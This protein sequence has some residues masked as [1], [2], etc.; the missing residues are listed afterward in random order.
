[1]KIQQIL[2]SIILLIILIIWYFFKKNKNTLEKFQIPDLNLECV[3]EDIT[4]Q[5]TS[6]VDR[7]E[8]VQDCENHI[9]YS[10][11]LTNFINNTDAT[12]A[13]TTNIVS[14]DMNSI[15]I[16]IKPTNIYQI[17]KLG[18][19]FKIDKNVEG[20]IM[21]LKFRRTNNGIKNSELNYEL[22]FHITR[23]DSLRINGHT[24]AVVTDTTTTTTLAAINTDPNDNKLTPKE[25]PIYL[26]ENAND[27][28][29][30]LYITIN[31]KADSFI[32]INLN[33]NI[34]ISI[35]NTDLFQPSKPGTTESSDRLLDWNIHTFN[36]RVAQI[37]A[38]TKDF[39][40]NICDYYNCEQNNPDKKCNFDLEDYYT[41]NNNK[42][43]NNKE[44]CLSACNNE[45][46]CNIIDCQKRCLECK[47]KN[48]LSFQKGYID[49][50]CPWYKNLIS[51][52]EAPDAPKIR[53]FSDEKHINKKNIPIIVIEWHK[54]ES[55]SSEIQQ[56]I[57]EIEELGIGSNG[58]Q[59]INV[60]Y[61]GEKTVQ[62]DLTNL[63][64]QT[65]YK[66]NV[67]TLGSVSI[68]NDNEDYEKITL[69]SKKSND[70]T[71]TTNGEHKKILKQTYDYFDNENENNNLVSYM[72]DNKTSNSD[73]I[74]NN[75][76]HNDIDIYQSLTN[77]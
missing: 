39:T 47:N 34:K 71:I 14:Y 2:I 13:N 60:P 77:L 10:D 40:E 56:Y 48:G 12:D 51:A 31:E 35:K 24:T 61:Q 74:L 55:I 33:N 19:Y 76:N 38:W 59:I 1:M 63:K 20:E 11:Y 70:L 54:P 53:G 7:S 41:E 46:D 68:K 17:K 52:P 66:I 18:L 16:K 69:I 72:C 28:K 27:Y 36:G 50:Y 75:I 6:S 62:K 67:F 73:H 3:T 58:L 15:Q 22:N 37:N 5:T 26:A 45:D 43:Y 65:T 30:W 64:P 44:D 49:T 32:D 57:I 8:Y 25:I 4:G 23:S 29:F 21:T 9:N 42:A